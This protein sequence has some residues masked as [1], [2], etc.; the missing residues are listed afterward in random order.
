ML[1]LAPQFQI[2]SPNC[3]GFNS[4]YVCAYDSVKR[5]I[6]F[7]L[8]EFSAL[9]VGVSFEVDLFYNPNATASSALVST[10]VGFTSNNYEVNAYSGSLL[11]WMPSCSFPC[12]SCLANNISA[13]TSCY[14]NSLIS[15]FSYLYIANNQCLLA[16]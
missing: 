10:L 11:N 2:S 14:Q 13:C 9:V 4:S 16:C 5:I 8:T 12:R 3:S 7:T 1:T 6:V 15:N